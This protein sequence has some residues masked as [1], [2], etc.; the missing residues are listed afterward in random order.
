[1]MRRVKD[2]IR[3][4]SGGA[5][6]AT[7]QHGKDKAKREAI[8]LVDHDSGLAAEDAMLYNIDLNNLLVPSLANPAMDAEL[9]AVPTQSG[10]TKSG[11]TQSVGRQT[12]GQEVTGGR[13]ALLGGHGGDGA[14]YAEQDEVFGDVGEMMM[15]GLLD[16]EAMGLGMHMDLGMLGMA[17]PTAQAKA[18]SMAGSENAAEASSPDG[19]VENRLNNNNAAAR[20]A[21]GSDASMAVEEGAM[22]VEDG[23]GAAE[24]RMDLVGRKRKPS[25][26][27]T[28]EDS[29]GYRGSLRRSGDLAVVEEGEEQLEA[30]QAD[31]GALSPA[32]AAELANEAA[33]LREEYQAHDSEHLATEEEGDRQDPAVRA[34]AAAAAAKRRVVK[35]KALQMV[36]D[37]LDDIQIKSKEFRDWTLDTSSLLAPRGLKRPTGVVSYLATLAASSPAFFL[38]HSTGLQPADGLCEGQAGHAGTK[39]GKQSVADMLLPKACTLLGSALM[40]GGVQTEAAAGE[41]VE[42]MLPLC[43]PLAA[44]FDQALQRGVSELRTASAELEGEV[45]HQRNRKRTK[46][47]PQNQAGG[48][49]A[50]LEQQG[51]QP[52]QSGQDHSGQHQLLEHP[53]EMHDMVHEL[54]FGGDIEVER[55]R[56]LSS[57]HGSTGL[58]SVGHRPNSEL[59]SGAAR[60]LGQSAGGL[61]SLRAPGSRAASET[62]GHSSLGLGQQLVH[63]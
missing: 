49:A 29:T 28:S 14:D 40:T 46:F 51:Q 18:S 32:S 21:R 30:G 45:Q 62:S 22:E 43:P 33:R 9:F 36:V 25:G 5:E 13:Q 57:P 60:L 12:G 1:M 55:L 31:H 38:L 17:D 50:A 41:K 3:V 63:R 4:E 8:T 61:A 35:R 15:G 48:A 44:V 54:P 39:A 26:A 19:A 56:A 2:A 23:L 59:G 52:A 16:D 37:D 10:Y 53:D 34:V 7:L 20:K 47:S 6:Q 42:L 11:L 58:G 27:P 24:D